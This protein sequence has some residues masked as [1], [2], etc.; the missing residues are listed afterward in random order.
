MTSFET[1]GTLRRILGDI[2]A[3]PT[4]RH[5]LGCYLFNNRNRD[6][7]E[8]FGD[9]AIFDLDLPSQERDWRR[10]TIGEAGRRVRWADKPKGELIIELFKLTGWRTATNPESGGEVRIIQGVYDSTETLAYQDA[11]RK[12]PSIFDKAG[13]LKQVAVL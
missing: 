5:F 1:L 6:H 3:H 9:D 4:W 7:K 10:L 8:L 2:D 13:S 11:L 12:H